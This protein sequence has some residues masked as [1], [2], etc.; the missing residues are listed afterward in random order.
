MIIN[1]LK[2]NAIDVYLH[3]I[4]VRLRAPF[5]CIE[6]YLQSYAVSHQLVRKFAIVIIVGGDL[7]VKIK[8]TRALLTSPGALETPSK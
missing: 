6:G 7:V 1:L 8:V 2:V 4:T 3:I 5:P